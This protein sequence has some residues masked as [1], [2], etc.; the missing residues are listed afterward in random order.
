MAAKLSTVIDVRG[1]DEFTGPLGHIATA[2]PRVLSLELT[3][4]HWPSLAGLEPAPIVLVCRT[5]K[6]SAAAAADIAARPASAQVNV[7]TPRDG[8]MERSGI[9]QWTGRACRARSKGSHHEKRCSFSTIRPTARNVST[10]ASDSLTTLPKKSRQTEVTV[11]HMADA[12]AKCQGRPKD[13]GRLLQRRANAQAR[14]CPSTATWRYAAPAWM[15]AASTTPL[16]WRGAC[17][18]TMDELATATAE[19]DKVLVF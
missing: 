7:V 14:A 10:T 5:D 12:V 8:A 1:P 15:R 19:A 17:R 16:S 3:S 9:C 13:A 18:S 2:R 4:P 6:R 11:F